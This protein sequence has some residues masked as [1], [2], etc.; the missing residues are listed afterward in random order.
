MQ[1][2]RRGPATLARP[3]ADDKAG[4]ETRL[5]ARLTTQLTNEGS[6][7][8][9]RHGNYKLNLG[10]WTVKPSQAAVRALIGC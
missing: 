2:L 10:P 3:E 6:E 1:G 4:R 5:A 9:G 7:G 8:K